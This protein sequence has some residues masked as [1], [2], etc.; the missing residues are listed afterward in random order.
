MLNRLRTHRPRHGTVVAYLA[1]FLALGGTGAYAIDGSLP[2]QNTV[3]SA[4]IINN[5]VQSADIKD[6]NLTTADIR[7]GAVTSGKIEDGGVLSADIG[8]GKVQGVDV[9]DNSLTGAD[10]D[11]GSLSGIAPAA[12]GLEFL[13]AK[14]A[15]LHD[16]P[17]GAGVSQALFTIGRVRLIAACTDAGTGNMSAN[18]QVAVD[19]SGPVLVSDGDGSAADDDVALQP[20]DVQFVVVLTSNVIAAREASFAILDGGNTTASGVGAAS[21]NPA[22]GDCVI[23]AQALG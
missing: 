7:A 5:E 20:F 9:Q 21:V 19:E 14:T 10:V 2:G 4:D 23:T 15:R 3:G 17:G 1:L 6:A 11:E 12:V 22:T 13:R 16:E 18:I 8:D